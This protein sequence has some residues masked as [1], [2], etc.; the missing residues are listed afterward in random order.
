MYRA[1]VFWDY[2][3]FVRWLT[4]LDGGITMV[5]NKPIKSLVNL[6]QIT[7][8]RNKPGRS[9]SLE[10]QINE[11]GALLLL[12]IVTSLVGKAGGSRQKNWP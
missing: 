10:A 8:V 1:W 9:S 12:S 2:L 4:H 3:V 7:M 11:W 5:R 6:A